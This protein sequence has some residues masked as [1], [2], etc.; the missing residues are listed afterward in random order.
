MRAQLE[1]SSPSL[2]PLARVVPVALATNEES[3]VF[4]TG[5][6]TDVGGMG[7]RRRGHNLHASIRLRIWHFYTT[8]FCPIDDRPAAWSQA[9]ASGQ[10]QGE[11]AT[12]P[13]DITGSAWRCSLPTSAR[14]P[15]RSHATQRPVGPQFPRGFVQARSV[16]SRPLFPETLSGPRYP[17]SHRSSCLRACPS[18]ILYARTVV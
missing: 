15:S 16:R 3:S 18:A 9:V 8:Y 14:P 1:R 13:R 2:L 11:V 5:H 4:G 10:V 17:A 12:C 6:M 7:S